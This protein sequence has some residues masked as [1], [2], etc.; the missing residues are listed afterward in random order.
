MRRIG[1][2]VTL[3]MAPRGHFVGTCPFLQ[4]ISRQMLCGLKGEADVK[5]KYESRIRGRNS[6]RKD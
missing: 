3:K 4:R 6:K 1:E 5:G 2:N